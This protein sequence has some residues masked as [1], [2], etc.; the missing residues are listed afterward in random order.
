MLKKPFIDKWDKHMNVDLK[1]S[2]E[3]L[4]SACDWKS[5]NESK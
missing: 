3:I 5:I 4:R 1:E 2:R